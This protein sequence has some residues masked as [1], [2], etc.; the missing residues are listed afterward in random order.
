MPN[1]RK[2]AAITWHYFNEHPPRILKKCLQC[3]ELHLKK[4][5]IGEFC[6]KSCKNSFDR[7]N[8]PTA[9]LKHSL[10]TRL[11]SSVKGTYKSKKILS[12]LGCSIPELRDHLERKFQDGMTW[13]NYC[14][15][16]WSVDH[17]RPCASFDF[18]S[19]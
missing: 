7:A 11:Y 10:R 9:R 17:I 5:F 15:D 16:G 8:N 4:F 2:K 3:S 18:N 14:F 6:S 1:S 19:P 13:D 12:L